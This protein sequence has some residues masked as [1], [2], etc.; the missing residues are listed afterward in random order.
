MNNNN[1]A[2]VRQQETSLAK[3][4]K[5]IAITN[6]ILAIS[7]ENKFIDFFLKYPE[8]TMIIYLYYPLNEELLNKYQRGL[9][10]SSSNTNLNWTEDFIDR[11]SDKWDWYALSKNIGIR[12]SENLIK[13]YEE[14]DFILLCNFSDSEAITWTEKLIDKYIEEGGEWYW[15]W[16]GLSRNPSLPWSLDFFNKYFDKWDWSGNGLSSNPNL[17]WTVD[18]IEKY[19]DRWDW[20]LLSENEGLPWSIELIERFINKWDYFGLL[21]NNAITEELNPVVKMRNLKI[22]GNEKQFKQYSKRFKYINFWIENYNNN[23]NDS[24]LSLSTNIN[25]IW[26]PDI[27]RYIPLYWGFGGLSANKGLPWSLEF[28][29]TYQHMW[30]F[31]TLAHNKQVWEDVFKSNLNDRIVNKVVDEVMR[32]YNKKKKD[33]LKHMGKAKK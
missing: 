9:S 16:Q 27:L 23:I 30:D 8:L 11:Y 21:R 1:R 29:E 25:V 15:D 6:K 31:V 26:T 3:I 4:G 19:H 28:I 13:K 14:K 24:W 17:S 22:K 10:V 5:K 12:W 18:F 20:P 2:I 7:N 32:Q 33:E